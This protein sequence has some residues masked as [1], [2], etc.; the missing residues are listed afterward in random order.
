MTLVLQPSDVDR[1]VQALRRNIFIENS[2]A[3]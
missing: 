2:D 1:S 3:L